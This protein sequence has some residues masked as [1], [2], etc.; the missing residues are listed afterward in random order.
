MHLTFQEVC[1][2]F[3]RSRWSLR[4][5]IKSG[6]FPAPASIGGKYLFSKEAIE[7]FERSV[8][9]LPVAGA[10]SDASFV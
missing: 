2:R 10:E 1:E 6:D 7:A 9:L 3:R 8:G 5:M 4:R